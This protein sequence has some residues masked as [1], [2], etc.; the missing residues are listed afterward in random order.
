MRG[1]LLVLVY[2]KNRSEYSAGLMLGAATSLLL[3]TRALRAAIL[4]PSTDHLAVV[5]K[6]LALPVL[7]SLKW[8]GEDGSIAG[9]CTLIIDAEMFKKLRGRDHAGVMVIRDYHIK[10]DSE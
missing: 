8:D 2:W 9:R 1:L 3:P 5:K 6:E 7:S 4:F 10:S